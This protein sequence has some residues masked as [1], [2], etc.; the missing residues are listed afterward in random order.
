MYLFTLL[1][2]SVSTVQSLCMLLWI[3]CK[4]NYGVFVYDFDI[5]YNEILFIMR[6]LICSVLRYF[7]KKA[8]NEFESGVVH[9]EVASDSD[10]LP[11][12]EGKVVG[13]IERIH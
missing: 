13:K 7:F 1:I 4:G 6:M 8:S 3:I 10:L 12:W 9:E 11:L 5:V 2:D